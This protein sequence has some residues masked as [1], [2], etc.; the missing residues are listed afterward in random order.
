MIKLRAAQSRSISVKFIHVDCKI[1]CRLSMKPPP[2]FPHL[3]L[4]RN[5]PSNV[6]SFTILDGSRGAGRESDGARNF[7]GKAG[8]MWMSTETDSGMI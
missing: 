1:S 5:N 2:P 7:T 6:I 4:P 8:T 3:P